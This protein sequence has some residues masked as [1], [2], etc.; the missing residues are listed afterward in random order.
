MTSKHTGKLL[1]PLLCLAYVVVVHVMDTFGIL[2]W[3]LRSGFDV[4]EFVAWLVLPLTFVV[5]SRDMDWGYFGFKRWRRSDWMLLGIFAALGMLAILVI[6]LFPSLRATY[7]SKGQ[8]S[9]LA[10]WQM[11]SRGLVWNISWL[12]GWEFIHRYFLLRQVQ[13]WGTN[14]DWLAVRAKKALRGL[15]GLVPLRAAQRD[16]L[17][18]HLVG[19]WP[20]GFGWLIVP[21]IEGVYHLQKPLME[22]GGMVFLS[23][24]LT[25]W[26]MKRQNILLPFL[27]HLAIEV[28]LLVYLL[29]V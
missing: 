3:Q 14:A 6:P 9:V 19:L 2:G 18:D 4:F 5:V 1:V 26:T 8:F 23:L 27:V 13:Q 21:L 20:G 11:A 24:V 29:A 28:G 10:K 17:L 25:A 22:A 7:H 12:P 15:L 16:T